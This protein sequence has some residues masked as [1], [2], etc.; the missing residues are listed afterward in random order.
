MTGRR[1]TVADWRLLLWVA[2]MAAYGA[3]A[4]AASGIMVMHA[5]AMASIPG[6]PTGVVY[7]TL[8]NAGGTNDRLLG[9]STPL[10]QRVEIHT[11]G[12]SHGVATMRPLERIDIA[13]GG[14]VEFKNGG[15]HLMLI[16]L[17]RPLLAG[18][19]LPLTLKFQKSGEQTVHIPVVALMLPAA[20]TP[21][22]K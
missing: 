6:A 11:G 10:A 20:P 21:A 9:A 14:M 2:A 3:P 22:R 16:G 7:L 12:M 13:V 8:H 18:T 5:K 15:N 17:L 4:M 19:T 1:N